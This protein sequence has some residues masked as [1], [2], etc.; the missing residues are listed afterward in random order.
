[1]GVRSA[2]KSASTA[3]S[4]SR[5]G[6]EPAHACASLQ[7]QPAEGEQGDASTSPPPLSVAQPNGGA[8]EC[9]PAAPPST[10]QPLLWGTGNGSGTTGCL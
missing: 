1:M 3:P 6:G 5:G 7:S 9:P 2:L 4:W 10:A 8:G